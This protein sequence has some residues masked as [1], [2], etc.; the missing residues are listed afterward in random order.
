MEE[1]NA[2]EIDLET[3]EILKIKA[4]ADTGASICAVKRA[5]ANT[6]SNWLAK[7]ARAFNVAH[8]GGCMI[9]HDKLKLTLYD[10][11]SHN[12]SFQEDFYLVENL[13][14]NFIL[15]RS[16]D[17]VHSDGV[18]DGQDLESLSD[19]GANGINNDNGDIKYKDQDTNN[20]RIEFGASIQSDNDNPK[21]KL[22][23]NDVELNILEERHKESICT[24]VKI[25]T[26]NNIKI[27]KTL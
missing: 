21:A 6:F 9:L 3:K 17:H 19:I 1:P 20:K 27:K 22:D 25:G 4:I 8:A 16:F 13:T 26:T 24:E 12:Q 15:S 10:S 14:H 5:I 7:D 18:F 11:N 2:I 23:I